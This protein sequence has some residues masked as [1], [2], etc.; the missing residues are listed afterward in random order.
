MNHPKIIH[1]IWLQGED[2]IPD[3]YQK[4]V[5]KLKKLHPDYEYKLWDDN[6]LRALV[7]T[8]TPHLLHLWDSYTFWVQRV[9]AGKYVALYVYGGFY[10][11]MDLVIKGPLDSIID[12]AEDRPAFVKHDKS[13]TL[14][15]DIKVNNN[16][17]YSPYPNHPFYKRMLDC[18]CAN[19]TRHIYEIKTYY[20]SK[21]TGPLYLINMIDTYDG[22]VFYLNDNEKS[23]IFYD[24]ED[25]SWIKD[26]V[27][28]THDRIFQLFLAWLI[29]TVIYTLWN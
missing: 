21:S 19:S 18:L 23:K 6:S 7:K 29:I 17:M 9:D 28:D 8:Y 4:A 1:Q 22:D 2:K 25:R 24:R 10:L 16:F 3:K 27:F 26:G 15:V 20:I 13:L 12:K 5:S 14:L 11:D